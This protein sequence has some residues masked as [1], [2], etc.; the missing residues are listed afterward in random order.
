ML[1]TLDKIKKGKAL[2]LY[3]TEQ[4]KDFYDTSANIVC[5][6]RLKNTH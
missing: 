2:R 3:L 6:Y 5:P 4:E 1:T